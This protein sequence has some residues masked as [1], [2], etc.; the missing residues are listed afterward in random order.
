[1]RVV[2]I[3]VAICALSFLT[4]L[5]GD[6]ADA[7]A[8]TGARAPVVR[9]ALP[10]PLPA[11]DASPLALVRTSAAEAATPASAHAHPAHARVKKAGPHKLLARKVFA[12]KA[13]RKQEIA[14]AF[15]RAHAAL[16]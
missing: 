14:A 12:A 16:A 7:P 11:P 1:M 4:G 5:A 3:A 10:P 15:E 2:L 13:A 8:A 9:L 6:L